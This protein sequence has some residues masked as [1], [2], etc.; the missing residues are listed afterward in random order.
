MHKENLDLSIIVPCFKSPSSLPALVN[1]IRQVATS[2]NVRYEILLV[3]DACPSDTWSLIQS[4]PNAK[5]VRA[6]LLGRNIGQHKATFFGISHAS[7][8]LIATMDD[9]YQH[10]PSELPK[11]FLEHKKGFDLVYGLPEVD[12]HSIVRNVASRSFKY[13]LSSLKILPNASKSSSFRLFN[14]RV[15]AKKMYLGSLVFNIDSLLLRNT[16]KVSATFVRMNKRIEGKSNYK[17]STLIRHSFNLIFGQIENLMFFILLFGGIA[18]LFSLMLLLLFT[19]STVGGYITVPG[20]ATI[21]LFMTFAFS[22]NFIIMG[23]IGRILFMIVTHLREGES[24]VWIKEFKGE[25]RDS[26]GRQS[27]WPQ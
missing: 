12:E 14:S 9:D 17:L 24:S 16:S 22:M 1:E 20:F 5:Q 23:F 26:S 27:S 6:F 18:T 8:A 11:L 25:K 13:L 7:G 21:I 3:C 4:I 2:L 15:L 10:L 19:W